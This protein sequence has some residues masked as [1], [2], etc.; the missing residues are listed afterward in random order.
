M[1]VA[2]GFSVILHDLRSAC[3][4]TRDHHGAVALSFT[5]IVEPSQSVEG[6]LSYSDFRHQSVDNFFG[7]DRT[8][9]SQILSF[10]LAIIL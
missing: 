6:S 1:R 5:Q 9:L 10:F 4:R 8:S 7:R 2:L 3:A